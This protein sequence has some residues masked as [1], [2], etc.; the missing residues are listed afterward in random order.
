MN[1]RAIAGWGVAVFCVLFLAPATIG[2]P[3]QESG[4]EPN[5]DDVRISGLALV[6][7][8]DSLKEAD[9]ICDL[10]GEVVWG[11]AA[12]ANG[13]MELWRVEKSPSAA[14]RRETYAP[15]SEP[16][17]GVNQCDRSWVSIKTRKR[18]VVR[19]RHLIDVEQGDWTPAYRLAEGETDFTSSRT[20]ETAK[21]LNLLCVTRRRTVLIT[22]DLR[23]AGAQ[24]GVGRHGRRIQSEDC[25]A[26]IW[27]RTVKA[28]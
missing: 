3:G 23:G 27:A 20:C 15:V 9:F 1:L 13:G 25:R 5:F 7:E 16:E 4:D 28:E 8:G 24:I 19:D 26:F 18:L 10:P 2:A 11:I 21:F 12:G 6:R 22:R 17:C 14:P